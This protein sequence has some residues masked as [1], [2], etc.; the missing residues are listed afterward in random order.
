MEFTHG[1]RQEVDADAQRAKVGAFDDGRV[2]AA[3][4]QRDRG[5][6]AADSRPGNENVFGHVPRVG[7]TTSISPIS[8]SVAKL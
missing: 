8:K 6:Q 7:R 2:D 5:G 4:V 1:M 3:G